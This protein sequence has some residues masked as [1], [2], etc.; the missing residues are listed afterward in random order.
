MLLADVMLISMYNSAN[1]SSSSFI[2]SFNL[3]MLFKNWIPGVCMNMKYVEA[4]DCSSHS[5]STLSGV[6]MRCKSDQT[7]SEVTNSESGFSK[8]WIIMR[9]RIS[10]N[11]KG[12]MMCGLHNWRGKESCG[13]LY[14]YHCKLFTLF[15]RSL[16]TISL[17]YRTVSKTY[18][19]LWKRE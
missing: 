18:T 3:L 17:L 11:D 14:T 5:C 12:W 10:A 6:E 7:S 4:K 8:I 13:Y 9:L 16:Q 19:E 1:V 2:L 15:G